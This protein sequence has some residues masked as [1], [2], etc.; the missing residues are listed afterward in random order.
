MWTNPQRTPEDRTPPASPPNGLA[1][2][3]PGT[4]AA[5]A[6]AAGAG[7][8]SA[9]AAAAAGGEAAGRAFKR[10]ETA[11]AAVGAGVEES[12]A[13]RALKRSETDLAMASSEAVSA[14]SGSSYA[15]PMGRPGVTSPDLPF[16][17]HQQQQAGGGSGLG[18]QHARSYSDVSDAASMSSAGGRV[19]G[20]AG[21]GGVFVPSS[22]GPPSLLAAGSFRPAGKFRNTGIEKEY[23]SGTLVETQFQLFK[24]YVNL[25][26]GAVH[27]C[28]Y[29]AQTYATM[30]HSRFAQRCAA[31]GCVFVT[32]VVAVADVVG[33]AYGALPPPGLLRACWYTSQAVT[34]TPLAAVPA[35]CE[36][37]TGFMIALAQQNT[38]MQQ[39]KCVSY[40][41][42][43]P[44]LRQLDPQ[45]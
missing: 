14:R 9:A 30:V 34:S 5:A 21:A 4:A 35:S 25:S 8:G 41:A 3:H 10:S 20:G 15:G 13:A 32:V 12:V 7:P 6:A 33:G 37:C 11:A 43:H 31:L 28:C 42:I 16:Q 19:V 36:F 45:Q 23:S 38:L 18:N 39:N 17:Q 1:A 44:C 26:M 40:T 27:V 22:P 29:C 24:S 2:L